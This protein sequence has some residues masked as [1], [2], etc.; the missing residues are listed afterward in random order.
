MKPTVRLLNR[1]RPPSLNRSTPPAL[2]DGVAG[3]MLRY[4]VLGLVLVD[5]VRE[6]SQLTNGLW[7]ANCV[8]IA[9]NRLACSMSMLSANG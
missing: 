8:R 2:P 9:L 6:Q 4:R 3:D 1:W 5:G 7:S